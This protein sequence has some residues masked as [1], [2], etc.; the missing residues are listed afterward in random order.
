MASPFASKTQSNPIP[1]PFDPPHTVVVRKLTGRELEAAQDAHRGSI[2]SGSS[3]S[4]AA[5]FRRMLE[6]G[7]SDPDV[8]KAIADP[9]TGYDRYA[10]VRSG[11]VSWSYPES[12]KPVAARPAVE[13][14]GGRP[15]SPAVEASDAVEDLDD[16]AVDFI[17][18]EVLRLTKPTLFQTQEAAKAD[19]KETDA[20]A[21]IA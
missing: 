6:K 9:L 1:L 21:P 2:A 3:R 5:T 12:V 7:A 13:A 4:W 20:A 15:A 16:D 10:L 14:K 8:M 18:T 19:Q 11:L 17:A